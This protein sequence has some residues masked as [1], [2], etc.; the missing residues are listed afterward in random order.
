MHTLPTI[1]RENKSMVFRR[2]RIRFTCSRHLRMWHSWVCD[3]EHRIEP[4]TIKLKN[5]LHAQLELSNVLPITYMSFTNHNFMLRDSKLRQISQLM[6]MAVLIF[7]AQQ[8]A[9]VQGIAFPLTK[10]SSKLVH[11]MTYFR[12]FSS[13]SLKHRQN[14]RA[15]GIWI[16]C[17]LD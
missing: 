13:N 4:T 7:M 5:K 6:W 17:L 8:F 1:W 2:S 10:K 9:K 12:S 3:Q 15:F 11:K 16:S 14:F